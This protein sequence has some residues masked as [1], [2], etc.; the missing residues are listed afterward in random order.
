MTAILYIAQI[1]VAVILILVILLQQGKGSDMGAAFGGASSTVFGGASGRQS[2]LVKV[3]IVLASLFM[4]GSLGL[5]WRASYI[6]KQVR[7]PKLPEQEE[8]SPVAPGAAAPTG[9]FPAQPGAGTNLPESG[10]N[11]SPAEP[12]APAKTNPVA[13]SA[14]AQKAPASNQGNKAPGKK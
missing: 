12:S 4:L 10:A 1:L 6:Q 9:N 11:P 8:K 3:T 5:S 13:P 14:P 2:F 7:V